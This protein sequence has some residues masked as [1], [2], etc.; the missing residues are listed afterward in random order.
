MLKALGHCDGLDSKDAMDGLLENA[1]PARGEERNGREACTDVGY[2]ASAG[3]LNGCPARS[4]N[5]AGR[6]ATATASGCDRE[7]EVR[8]A[9]TPGNKLTCSTQGWDMATW[10]KSRG[11]NRC[12]YRKNQL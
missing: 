4:R 5:A 10:E 8:Q 12:T 2:P 6:F 11:G 3:V 1:R 9:D 7:G